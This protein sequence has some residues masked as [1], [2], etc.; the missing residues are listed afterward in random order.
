MNR[1][2]S[3]VLDFIVIPAAATTAWFAVGALM[4][5]PAQ[6]GRALEPGQTHAQVQALKMICPLGLISGPW[7]DER[8]NRA[9]SALQFGAEKNWGS[10]PQEVAYKTCNYGGYLD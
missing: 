8:I 4:P 9:I 6:A 3:S 2:L 1:I 7:R 10:N 5:T